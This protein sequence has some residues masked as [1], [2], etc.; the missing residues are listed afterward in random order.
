MPINRVN[1]APRADG[2]SPPGIASGPVD[3]AVGER[4]ALRLASIPTAPAAEATERQQPFDTGLFTTTDGDYV[5]ISTS[6]RG[7]ARDASGHDSWYVN[8]WVVGEAPTEADVTVQLQIN[9]NGWVDAGEPRRERT[10]QGT[11]ASANRANAFVRCSNS[12]S[13]LWRS[14]I[15]VDLVGFADSPTQKITD[16]R[17]IG[18]GV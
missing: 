9:L 12:R 14:I 11:G 7:G 17:S 3:L 6:N 10:R 13:H 5:H 16:A 1:C 2:G 8:P 15:D 18:C 4:C